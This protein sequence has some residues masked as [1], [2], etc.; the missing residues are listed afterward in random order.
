[1]TKN[2]Y[3]MTFFDFLSDMSHCLVDKSG[4][5]FLKYYQLLSTEI[6][7]TLAIVAIKFKHPY[8]TAHA[9]KMPLP[10]INKMNKKGVA[11]AC[12]S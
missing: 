6:A 5:E 8:P 4:V 12:Y 11:I 2:V 7:V 1:M 3:Q 10:K 9:W